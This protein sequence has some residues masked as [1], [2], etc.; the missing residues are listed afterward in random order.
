MTDQMQPTHDAGRPDWAAAFRE[1]E[2]LDDDCWTFLANRA[3]SEKF[4]AGEAIFREGDHCGAYVLLSSGRIKVVK[5]WTNGRAITLYRIVGGCSCTASTAL[6]FIH[7][8]YTADAIAETDCELRLLRREDFLILFERSTAF[9]DQVCREFGGRLA[10]LTN[11]LEAALFRPVDARLADWLVQH[12]PEN[13]VISV[14]HRDLAMELGTVREV[15]SRHLKQLELAGSVQLS[16]GAIEVVD[17]DNLLRLAATL[18][19]PYPEVNDQADPLTPTRAPM[20]RVDAAEWTKTLAPL[21][22]IDDDVWHYVASRAQIVDVPAGAR[23]FSA[24]D[25]CGHY[26]IVKDGAVQV[27]ASIPGAR[28][29]LLYRLGPGEACCATAS[30]ILRRENHV[31]NSI[32]EEDTI[33][34]L[35]SSRDF[36]H[37]FHQSKG[38]RDFVVSSYEARIQQL[39]EL[40]EAFLVEQVDA[41]LARCLLRHAKKGGAINVSHEELASEVGTA[42]EVVSRNLKSW[43]R[44]GCVR[45][46]RRR[47]ELIDPVLLVEL[48][49]RR[50]GERDLAT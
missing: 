11:R 3:A 28:E 37:A 35:I 39:L 6:L 34:V 7:G 41:R 9:R 25:P 20:Q 18:P 38:F 32:A 12:K 10:Q 45:L 46:G 8:F 29:F 33:A 1:L 2:V 13:G 40:L 26:V 47:I 27:F 23:P 22:D 48:T 44:Q 24:G 14:T 17:E 5:H 15:I 50:A 49:Q 43:E 21:A 31:T 30:G 19:V 36:H 42:R 4:R 16:R